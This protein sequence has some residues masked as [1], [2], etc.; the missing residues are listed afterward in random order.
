[1]PNRRHTSRF[2]KTPPP[3][4]EERF[5]LNNYE[6]PPLDLT[7]RMVIWAPVAVALIIGAYFLHSYLTG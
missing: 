4:E 6:R 7:R 3:E 2:R 1:M 5:T